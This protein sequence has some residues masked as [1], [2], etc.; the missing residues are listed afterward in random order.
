MRIKY[1]QIVTDKDLV[2]CKQ[3]DG[4]EEVIM[5]VEERNV[6]DDDEIKNEV[7]ELEF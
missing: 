1:L 5:L 2:V 7:T 3:V 6:L 4:D